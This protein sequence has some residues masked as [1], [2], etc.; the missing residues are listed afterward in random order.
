MIQLIIT[1]GLLAQ[2]AQTQAQ[3]ADQ[4][5][6]KTWVDMIDAEQRYILNYVGCYRLNTDPKV[7]TYEVT[8]DDC[9]KP[10]SIDWKNLEKARKLAIKIFD[11]KEKE[12]K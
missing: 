10:T 7:V 11:L 12:K 1:L 2:A 5:Y 4:E 9:G 3:V 8:V 6:V